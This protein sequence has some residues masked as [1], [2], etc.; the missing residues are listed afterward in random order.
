MKRGRTRMSVAQP[1]IH[2]LCQVEAILKRLCIYI[3]IDDDCFEAANHCRY[4]V[5]NATTHVCIRK[6]KA[7]L[8]QDPY[9]PSVPGAAYGRFLVICGDVPV[10]RCGNYCPSLWKSRSSIVLAAWRKA[11]NVLS[12]VRHPRTSPA[13]PPTSLQNK[14]FLAI[15]SARD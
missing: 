3:G 9:L 14:E 1:Q 10:S 5:A 13:R 7:L 8:Y 2:N 15:R 11:G 6:T 12:R 4:S